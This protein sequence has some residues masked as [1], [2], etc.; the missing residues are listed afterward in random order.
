MTGG[1]QTPT[2]RGTPASGSSMLSPTLLPDEASPSDSGTREAGRHK[3]KSK[4]KSKDAV[5][6]L[7][8]ELEEKLR[9][10]DLE[11]EDAFKDVIG[12]YTSALYEGR[13]YK[14]SISFL[15]NVGLYMAQLFAFKS[16][17]VANERAQRI[18]LLQELAESKA[19][20]ERERNA[21]GS[22]AE[23]HGHA[24]Q[25]CG[26]GGR[27]LG[28]RRGTGNRPERVASGHTAGMVPNP[29]RAASAGRQR[30][31]SQRGG[32]DGRL[33]LAGGAPRRAPGQPSQR[34]AE[35]RAVNREASQG[36]EA[37]WT[38]VEGQP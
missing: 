19:Q 33:V 17:E 10:V 6:G 37:G 30:G 36:E 3:K 2:P 11:A 31:N 18:K 29:P 27:E 12:I 5:S 22:V 38:Q 16:E 35:S 4:E 24:D 21:V 32:S 15:K 9:S 23:E 20:R 26:S 7:H 1:N 28:V 25:A 8:E 14:T 34:R 13:Y